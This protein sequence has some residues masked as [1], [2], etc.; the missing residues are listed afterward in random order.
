MTLG[1]AG[2][3]GWGTPDA[4]IVVLIV[5]ALLVW[6]LG[7]FPVGGGRSLWSRA[8][9]ATLSAVALAGIVWILAAPEWVEE[10]DRVEEGRLVVLVDGSR[11]MGVLEPDGAPRSDGVAGLLDRIGPAEVYTFGDRLR[12]GA[13]TQFAD[14]DSDLGGAIDAISR[15]YAG[16]R[17]GGLVVLSDGIDRG[18]LRRRVRAGVVPAPLPGPL[19]VYQ[20]GTR[21]GR[22]DL[23]IDEVRAGSFAF[24]RSPFSIDVSVRGIG[25]VPPSVAVALTR[26]GQP[27]GSAIARLGPDGK[28]NAHF[29]VTPDRAGRYLYEVSVPMVPGDAVPANQQMGLAVSVVRDRVRVL[30]VCGSPSWDQKF[31]RLFLKEDQAVDLVSF[32]ILRTNRDMNSGYSENEL[33]LIKFPYENL[34]KGELSSFDLVIFQN[35]DYA[36]YFESRATELLGNVAEYVRRGGSFVML[37]GDRSFDL[38]EYA[39][40]PI[41]DILPVTLGSPVGADERAGVPRLT[42]A[43]ARH[44]VTQLT[45]S[46]ADNSLAWS[47][48]APMYGFNLVTGAA[49]GAAVLLEHPDLKGADGTPMPVL[50]VREVGKGRTMALTADASWRWSFAEAGSGQGN[51]AYLKFWKGAMRWLIGDPAGAPVTVETARENYAPGE[52]ATALVR[53]RDVTFAAVDGVAVTAQLSGPEGNQQL[54]G[55]TDSRGEV[56]FDLPTAMRGAHRITVRAQGRGGAAGDAQTVYGVSTRDPELDEVEPDAVFLQALAAQAGGKYV[57]PGGFEPPTRDESAGRRVRDRRVTPLGTQP[58]VGAI[59]AISASLGWFVRR[60]AGLR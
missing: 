42:P 12:A 15:K 3:L 21:Q 45:G 14:G 59:V 29:S 58:V 41:A 49:S 46:T 13:P 8:L 22:T 16:E 40:T 57:A 5:F 23:A 56:R 38:G 24:L 1:T 55:V 44:P 11:S 2:A 18:G 33:S 53:V 27:A 10:G 35:F 51:Q 48:L 19:T 37:G 50:A 32:F 34:F 36:P 60:R 20:L 28:G 54:S 17:L 7:L 6:A 43:G 9:E 31:L 25:A 4:L 47:Q 39:G 52:A 30:Q 26:D